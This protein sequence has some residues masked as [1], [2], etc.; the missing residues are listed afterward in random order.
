MGIGETIASFMAGAFGASRV[1]AYKF[2]ATS[3]SELAYGLLADVNAGR[4]RMYAADGS[5]EYS[6]FWKQVRAVRY[7]VRAYQAMTFDVDP[8]EGHDDFLMSLAL[9]VE[10]AKVAPIR[11]ATARGA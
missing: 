5:A 3:K 4:L 9:L 1:T 6:E 10:A 2:S 8:T 11:R 7:Q